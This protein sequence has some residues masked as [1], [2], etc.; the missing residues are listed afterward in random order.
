MRAPC[1][2]PRV[3]HALVTNFGCTFDVGSLAGNRPN[4]DHAALFWCTFLGVGADIK[5]II[6]SSYFKR[7]AKEGWDLL[8]LFIR[9]G[10]IR[11]ML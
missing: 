7:R 3:H 11:N 8:D 1:M 10:I 4:D 6:L 5:I 9:V 2:T